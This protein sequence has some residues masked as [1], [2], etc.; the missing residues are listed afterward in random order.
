MFERRFQIQ[1]VSERL[2]R[3]VEGNVSAVGST[4]DGENQNHMRS[5]KVL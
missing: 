2:L 4:V 1:Y 3:N 5:L